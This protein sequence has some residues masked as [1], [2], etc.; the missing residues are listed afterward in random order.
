MTELTS[1]ESAQLENAGQAINPWEGPAPVPAFRG[2]WH[3][4]TYGYAAPLARVLEVPGHAVAAGEGMLAGLGRDYYGLIDHVLGNV[5]GVRKAYTEPGIEYF[6][7]MRQDATERAQ[8]L[9]PGPRQTGAA[10]QAGH[11]L[12]TALTLAGF[13]GVAGGPAAAATLVGGGLGY[14]RVAQLEAGG[15]PSGPAH[16]LGLETAATNAAG[17]LV[18]GLSGIGSNLALRLLTGA[19][20]NVGF[21]MA[22]RYLD[23]VTLQ[24]AGYPEMAQQQKV[25]D[26]TSMLF[27]AILG[28]GFGALGHLHQQHAA[29]ELAERLTVLRQVPGME[30]AVMAAQLGLRAQ[31]LAPGI[32]ADPAAAHAHQ[33]ALE[34][35][36][37]D[38]LAGE[39]VNVAETGVDTA[40]FVPFY[41]GSPHE[42]E[43][44][45]A[46]RVG[47]GEGA[48]VYGHG[49]AYLAQLRDVGAAYERDLSRDRPVTY[50]GEPVDEHTNMLLQ[51]IRSN[52]QETIIKHLTNTIEWMEKRPEE[53]ALA[54]RHAQALAEA[55]SDLAL[56]RSVDPAQISRPAGY[57]YTVRV[58]THVVESALDLDKKLSEQSGAVK[59]A[60]EASPEVRGARSS[61]RQYGDVTGAE[62]YHE[63]GQRLIRQKYNVPEENS[64][65]GTGYKGEDAELASAFLSAHGVHGNTYLDEGSRGV[66][67]G[68]RNLVVFDAKHAQIVARE[69]ARPFVAPSAA[70][71][72]ID[73]SNLDPRETLLVKSF[74]DA[75]LLDAQRNVDELERALAVRLGRAPAAAEAPAEAVAPER[76]PPPAEDVSKAETAPAAPRKTPPP[77]FKIHPDEIPRADPGRLNDAQRAIETRFAE[78]LARDPDLARRRYG[79]LED[80]DGGRIL[81]TDTARELSEDYLADRS[82]SAAVHEPASWLIKRMY[83]EMIKEPPKPGFDPLVIIMAGGTGAGKSTVVQ[84]MSGELFK[85]AQIIYDTNFSEITGAIQKTNDAL[86]NGKRVVRYYVFRDPAEALA[87]GALTRAMKQEAKWGS[88]RTVPIVEHTNTHVGAMQVLEPYAAHFDGHKDVTLKYIDNA[89][90]PGNQVL[91]SIEDIPRLEYNSTREQVAKTLEDEYAA[92]RISEAVYRGFGGRGPVREPGG[93]GRP[94]A[95]GAARPGGAGQPEEKRGQRPADQLTHSVFTASGRQVEVRPK[96]VEAATLTTSDKAGYPK[97][98]QPRQRGERTALASQVQEMARNLRPEMLGQSAEADRG[99]PIIG[100]DNVVESGNGR[101]MALRQVFDSLPEQALAYRKFLT[102]SGYDVTG[103]KEP[104]LVRERLTAMSPAERT[105]F[106]GEANVGSTATYSPVE[107]AQADAKLLDS[108]SLAKMAGADLTT[109]TNAAFL[110]DFV[111]G[112]APSE[113]SSVM[114]PDGTISQ[115]GVRRVQ[116]AIL[117]KAYG[118]TGE[119]GATL[120]RLLESTD[121]NLK[122][123]LNALIDAA[124]AYARLKQM[125]EDG[126]IGK[127]FDIAPAIVQAVEDVARLQA[128]GQSL[129]EHFA[130]ADIFNSRALATQAFYDKAGEKLAGR[131][132]AAAALIRYADQ[133]MAQRLNQGNL[134]GDPPA[135][136]QELLANAKKPETRDM[137]GLR[138]K[139]GELAEGAMVVSAAR[140]ALEE[141]PNLEL[142]DENGKVNR[143]SAQLLAAS[144]QDR[145]TS[146][147]APP[148]IEAATDCFLRRGP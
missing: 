84:R 137:F 97:E 52:G 89:R 101:V 100:A 118:E 46:T 64:T 41:H 26:G 85:R 112:L 42:F 82:Q 133:A 1:Q 111:S 131:D 73:T 12:L 49:A 148:A 98:L 143:A 71:P 14:E 47:T 43:H 53:P 136:P 99:A 62:A 79:E 140:S 3:D 24:A 7:Q 25:W 130:Q 63:L 105:A 60:F 124:P 32:P 146:E 15:M 27:D 134:F 129:K 104:V 20:A 94:A 28:G 123:T 40:N 110:R 95:P 4:D 48:Q 90:G 44:F 35:A 30:D 75:G 10:I 83:A 145:T 102:A 13:G 117:A 58:P 34:K 119:S 114:N 5:P 92:G 29:R 17:V 113:R 108:G 138:T 116:A 147:R 87:N 36:T 88:G 91:V 6:D 109:Y 2:F 19:S 93:A 126:V 69:G 139:S 68:T 31:S 23:H 142:P 122:S 51:S 8:A 144:E 16:L 61:G 128:S 96:L 66:G 57:L 72:T 121:Q 18:P 76:A 78:Q 59:A 120:G 70:A 135:S 45:D 125:I 50:K 141:K 81:N 39:P 21:G 106:T 74:Q 65:A 127:E 115:A 55:R 33:A 67:G 132:K 80:A 86:D 38:L 77:G 22:N 107:Q 9:T 54:G 11:S 37:A 103:M 56:V